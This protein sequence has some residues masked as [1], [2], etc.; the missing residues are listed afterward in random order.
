MPPEVTVF[1]HFVTFA[2]KLF[3]QNL[4]TCLYDQTHHFFDSQTFIKFDNCLIIINISLCVYRYLKESYSQSFRE[5]RIFTFNLSREKHLA[6]IDIAAAIVVAL[7]FCPRE[8]DIGEF[9]LTSASPNDSGAKP[10]LDLL[11]LTGFES[12]ISCW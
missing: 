5:Q 12:D 7:L 9:S 10:R 2:L 8:R 6:V 3:K 11:S 1:F 4:I